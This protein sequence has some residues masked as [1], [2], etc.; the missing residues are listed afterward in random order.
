MRI[1]LSFCLLI[2]TTLP[3]AAES[4]LTQARWLQHLNEDLIPFWTTADAIGDP[5]GM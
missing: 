4:T 5:V 3:L 2:L 1:L